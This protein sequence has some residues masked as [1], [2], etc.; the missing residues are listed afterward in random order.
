MPS[1]LQHAAESGSH[2]YHDVTGDSDL[3]RPD[4]TLPTLF[5]TLILQRASSIFFDY[6][7]EVSSIYERI[8][9][10]SLRST[11]FVPSNK[12]VIALGWKPER[13]PP[14]PGQSGGI[15]ITEDTLEDNVK[16]WVSAHIVPV[17]Y[18]WAADD[19]LRS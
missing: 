11:L 7:R 2:S 13:G 16:K 17:R 9:D 3:S 19:T 14:P 4:N 8:S 1:T 6:L 5:D 18:A 10:P 15:E 12:A